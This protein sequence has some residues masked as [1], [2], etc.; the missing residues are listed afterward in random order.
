M[1]LRSFSS[2]I[3]VAAVMLPMTGFSVF[4]TRR[5]RDHIA[6]GLSQ[7]ISQT[8]SVLAFSLMPLAGA[9]A[10][11]FSAPLFAAL[12]SIIWLKEHAGPAR[13][14]TLLVGFFGVL[15]VT[16]PGAEF[17]DAR[18]IVRAGQRDHVRQRHRRGPRHDQDGIGQYA[19][20]LADG[21]DHV[22][23][24][25]FAFVRLALPR[26]V[27]AVLLFSSG[28]ANACGQ[29]FWTQALRLAPAT[30]VS[31]FYYLMLVWAL[32]IGF[33]VWGDIPTKGLLIGSAIVVASGLFLLWREARLQRSTNAGVPVPAKTGA[34]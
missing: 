23:S 25:L 27:D 7:A 19:F 13:W 5:P 21:D 14:G 1:F 10:I 29:Y 12:V 24:Q 26:P 30:A 22:L 2:L 31:P 3:V 11:N 34:S 28:F 17:A 6:R 15:I 20:D 18:R 4:A 16:N 9:V 33:L 32:I 8:F